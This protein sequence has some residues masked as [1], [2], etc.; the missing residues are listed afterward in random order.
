MKIIAIFL[1]VLFYSQIYSQ[2]NNCSLLGRW[3][4]GHTMCVATQ[5]NVAFIGNGCYLTLVDIST[6]DTPVEISNFLLPN[7]VQGVTVNGNYAYVA[8]GQEGLF[9]IDISDKNNPG[10][11]GNLKTYNL[12]TK[13]FYSNN[14]VY[15]MYEEA[16]LV[17]IDVSTPSLP[18]QV[19][20]LSNANITDIYV[21]GDFAYIPSKTSGLFIYDIS[22]RAAPAYIG[23]I[24]GE[25]YMR[26]AVVRDD[27]AFIGDG[28]KLSIYDVT[29]KTAPQKLSSIDCVADNLVLEGDTI[30]A[31]GTYQNLT[32]VDVGDTAQPK[33]TGSFSSTNFSQTKNI[34]VSGKNILVADAQHGLYIIDATN[35]SSMTEVGKIITAGPY[36]TDVVVTDD[37]AF[38]SDFSNGL[39]ILDL[40]NLDSITRISNLNPATKANDNFRC[41]AL[42]GNYV[43]LGAYTGLFIIDVSNLEKPTLVNKIEAIGVKHIN[44]LGNYAYVTF[45]MHGGLKIIDISDPLNPVE[46]GSLPGRAY[47]IDVRD[48]LAYVVG[49]NEEGFS[50]VSI[51]DPYDPKVISYSAIDRISFARDIFVKGDFAYTCGHG[52]NI[53]DISDPKNPK[54]VS[55]LGGNFWSTIAVID[56]DAYVGYNDGLLTINIFDPENPEIIGKYETANTY[57]S[58]LFANETVIYLTEAYNGMYVLNNN[59]PTGIEN[60]KETGVALFQNY[61]NPFKNQTTIDYQLPKLA[62]VSLKIYDVM[63]REIETLVSG[64]RAAGKYSIQWNG[65]NL[66][67]Q[68]LFYR[69]KVDDGTVITKKMV[70]W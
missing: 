66:G 23:T 33:V 56:G 46:T 59:F 64:N 14:F 40:S 43:Y 62:N 48:S 44:V 2:T 1:F 17:I 45:G 30:F 29:D 50:I 18:T 34:A 16:G 41:L 26:S 38:M 37:H 28:A 35:H 8:D 3:A 70:N 4:N 31:I 61:P 9:I 19:S 15:L 42:Q 58:E 27:T 67:G 55:M 57:V 68:Q 13:P 12:C 51:S 52:L 25:G 54:V 5:N 36:Y 10:Q 21:E 63:G 6:P 60:L 32:T 47:A 7:M 20:S 22:D 24:S 39:F 69:L 65:K 53:T 11:V 49:A